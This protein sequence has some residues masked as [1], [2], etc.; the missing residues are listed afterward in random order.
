MNKEEVLKLAKLARV[1]IGE[2]EA[3]KLSHEFDAILKYVGEIKGAQMTN[4]Q[5]PNSKPDLRNIMREDS[6]PHEAG[7]YTE[8]ILSQAPQREGNFLKV[9]KIL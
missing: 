7:I 4:D 9:K 5:I 3:D 6:N 1:G 2:D 8:A